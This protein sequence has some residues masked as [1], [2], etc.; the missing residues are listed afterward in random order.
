MIGSLI[1]VV[2]VLA[3]QSCLILCN[4]MNHS[5]PGNSLYGIFQARI[6]DWDVISFSRGSSQPRD[7]NQV[8]CIGRQM[9]YH[10][11]TSD[12]CFPKRKKNQDFLDGQGSQREPGILICGFPPGGDTLWLKELKTSDARRDCVSVLWR[13][14][15]SFSA[16][17]GFLGETAYAAP[18]PPLSQMSQSRQQKVTLAQSSPWEAPLGTATRSGVTEQKHFI[19]AETVVTWFYYFDLLSIFSMPTKGN[20][21]FWEKPSEHW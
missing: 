7:W 3:A 8:S 4:A 13:K 15:L 2:A 14:S 19:P 12:R 9:L 11:A 18:T 5:L 1:F 21:F 16:P 10:W 6:L 20:P 17:L